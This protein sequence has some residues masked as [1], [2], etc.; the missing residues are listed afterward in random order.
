[1]VFGLIS[2]AALGELLGANGGKLRA[3][4]EIIRPKIGVLNLPAVRRAFFLGDRL[5][6]LGKEWRTG[7]DW[8]Y[9]ERLNM[10]GGEKEG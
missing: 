3:S 9:E 6:N 1:V 10:L 8:R 7:A 5:R 2:R 4:R